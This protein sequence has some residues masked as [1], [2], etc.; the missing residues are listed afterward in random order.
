MRNHS[1]RDC[2]SCRHLAP[3]G[4]C[5]CLSSLYCTR[6]RNE[7]DGPCPWHRYRRETEPLPNVNQEYQTADHEALRNDA[8]FSYVAAWE[9]AGATAEPLLHK[10]QL[11]FEEVHPSTRSYK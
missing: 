5:R 8:D 2:G 1:D 9:Y 4:A 6:T 11:V 7:S 3:T 10:E